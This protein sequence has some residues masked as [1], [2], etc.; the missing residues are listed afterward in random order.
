MAC[1]VGESFPGFFNLDNKG[2]WHGFDVNFCR[3]LSAAVFG[4]PDQVSFH[5]AT[6]V[7]RFIQLQSG[8]V[9][10]LTRSVTRTLSR[11][12]G[13]GLEFTGVTFFNGQGF[14]VRKAAGIAHAEQL[15]GATIRTQTGTTTERNVADWFAARRL[16]FTP[17]VFEIADQAIAVYEAGR[18]DAC[19]T[20][21]STLAARQ[22]RL[23]EPD[24]NVILP[25]TINVALD[26]PVVRRDDPQW[27]AVV[28]WA[29]FA[30]ISAEAHGV[31]A[32]NVQQMARET[33]APETRRLLGVNGELGKFLDLS[34]ARAVPVIANIGNYGE[35]YARNL[36]G[37]QG[38][39]IP[40]DGGSNRLAR[41]GGLLVAPPFE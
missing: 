33:A 18:C 29:L 34:T 13:Q 30:L 6:P 40:R 38:V 23:R 2:I 11:D 7:A 37:G 27:S 31:T 32:A 41:D 22:P 39:V 20:D 5:V 21:R 19:T 15:A 3:A 8:E 26:G 16:A 25:D 1:G 17:V 10:V 36:G 24:A 28:R 35:M 4:N 12:S 14:L 9:D